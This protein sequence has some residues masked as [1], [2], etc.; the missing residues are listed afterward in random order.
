MKVLLIGASGR[1]GRP[2]V[3]EL[4]SRGHAVTALVR[5]PTVLI[6]EFPDL[7]AVA[8]DVFDAN[9]LGD[10]LAGHDVLVSAVA[11]RDDAQRD[12]T[13]GALTRALADA[14]AAAGVRWVSLGGAGSLRTANGVDLVD[15]PDF[16]EA[17]ASESRGFRAALH[18]L[19]EHAPAGLAWT[20]VSPPA[21]IVFDGERT[22]CYRTSD[23]TLLVDAQGRSTL[24]AADLAVAVV[25]EV[26]SAAHVGARF[27]VGS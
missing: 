27:A 18:D 24:S 23:D 25:D 9:L 3:R 13:P 7:D 1:V 8:G 6:D 22:G 12:R 20:V 16:P 14:A 11:L 10:V 2:I 4:R 19:R 26:D 17:A 21:L 5:D 15:T